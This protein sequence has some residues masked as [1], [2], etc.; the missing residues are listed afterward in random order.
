MSAFAVFN[1][2]AN[3]GRV[4]CDWTALFA[5]LQTIFPGLVATPSGG[6]GQTARLVRD[7]L[8]EG[9][10][11]IVAVGGDG[12]VNEAVNGFFEQGAQLAPDA[13]LSIV[14]AGAQGDIGF[15]LQTGVAA[16]LRLARARVHTVDLGHVSCVAPGGGAASRF[17]LG[18]ASFGLTGDTARRLNRSRFLPSHAVQEMLARAAWQACRVRLMADGGFDEIDGITAVGVANGQRFGGGLLASAAADNTDGA[19]DIAVLAGA[20]RARTGQVLQQ[21]RDGGAV[22]QLR[23]LRSARLTAAPIKETSRPVWVETD[24]EALGL[25][26]ASFE[27][28]PRALRLRF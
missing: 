7:A 15:G 12:T 26:P 9:H 4:G 6:R 11:E 25:L 22:A 10:L 23:R 2:A 5:A 1:P 17:F 24:G 20:R 8:R 3:H 21:L 14:P 16:A 19:F 27:S 18:S 28:V 13:V